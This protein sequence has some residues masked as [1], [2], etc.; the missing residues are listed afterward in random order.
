L[1]AAGFNAV[2]TAHNP[3]SPAFLETCDRLGLLVMDEAFDCWEKGK[4]PHD[5]SEVFKDWWQRDLDAMVLRDRNHPS[6]VM[7]SLGNEVYERATAEGARIARMLANR[8]RELDS[9]RPITAGING[10]W[11]KADWTEIDPVFATLD[12]SGYNYELPR[13]AEDHARLPSRVILSTESYQS[14]AFQNWATADDNPYVI[15]DFVWSA[16]DYLGEAGIGRVFPPG[17]PAVR[18]WEGVQ[19]PWHGAYCGDLD[20]TGWRKPVSHYR[21][22][23]WDR[24][25]KLYAAVL[26]PTSDGKP[27]NLT[28]W[29]LPPALPSW[30]WPGQDGK[31]LTVEVYS[32]YDAVRLYLN[33]RL[34][35]E[36][37]TTRTGEFKAVFAVPYTPGTLKAVG[38]QYGREVQTF[39]LTT[40]GNATRMRLTPDR[41]TIQAG[42]QDLSFVTIEVT[43][44]DGRLQPNANPAVRFTLSGPG[45]IAGI[46]SGDMTAMESYQANSHQ[47]FHGRALVVIRSTPEA[48]AI[49]LVASAPGLADAV[50]TIHAVSFP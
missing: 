24:G 34:L 8:I 43:D 14:E 46:G 19:Y 49:K 50:M 23:I 29:S 10:T 22:I 48:G 1:K 15:G 32:R 21:N 26:A 7:W 37:P 4:N 13:H 5:Y 11:P 44:R 18:H 31:E 40:A 27:W 47:V 25:E 33:S 42:G 36:K 16:L 41:S 30:T 2:R 45:V 38:V 35:G 39:T 3:P 17:Q 28:P 6:V 12:V 9:T 20:I